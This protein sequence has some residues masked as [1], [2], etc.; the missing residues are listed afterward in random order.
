VRWMV[1]GLTAISLVS[2]FGGAGDGIAHFAH[3]GG[4]LGAW[5]YLRVLD[6]TTGAK[7]FRAHAVAAARPTLEAPSSAVAR[8]S[9]ID[10]TNLHPVNL[11]ELD[12]VLAKLQQEGIGRLTDGERE[13]LERFSQ[14]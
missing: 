13:F 9:K 12:R 14:R 3:L 11:E 1:V 4:F 5:V 6:Q 8:W 2:G 7:R 10:R